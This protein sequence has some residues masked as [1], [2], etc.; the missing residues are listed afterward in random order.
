ETKVSLIND[1]ESMGYGV[2]TLQ[3]DQLQTLNKGEEVPSGH[4]ALIAAGTGLGE[5]FLIRTATGVLP[6]PSEGGHTDF[7][8]RN[9]LEIELLNYCRKTWTHVSYERVLSGPGLQQI[10]NFLTDSG[11]ATASSAVVERI[12]AS[13]DSSA[14][15]SAAALNQECP[16]CVKTLD[17]FVAIYGAEAGNLALSAKTTGGVFLGGSIAPKILN[18]L[19]DGTFLASFFEKG[20]METL[21]RSMPV[22]VILEPKTALF[23]AAYYARRN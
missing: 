7:A 21:M 4:M 20:R 22:K 12:A 1:L 11:I 9:Q 8:P 3:E 14:T 10:Y 18:K 5:A 17:T 13:S 19:K 16:L 2:L 6:V 15:I 23:G